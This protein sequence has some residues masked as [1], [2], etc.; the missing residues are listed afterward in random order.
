VRHCFN[1]DKNMIWDLLELESNKSSPERIY[2][3]IKGRHSAKEEGVANWLEAQVWGIPQNASDIANMHGVLTWA[4]R[5]M[6]SSGTYVAQPTVQ[7]NGTYQTWG[8]GT[9]TATLAGV[10]ASSALY[11][12]FRNAVATYSGSVDDTLLELIMDMMDALM[13]SPLAD[14]EGRFEVSDQIQ[15]WPNRLA[16]AYKKLVNKGNDD[17]GSGGKGDFFPIRQTTANGGRMVAVPYLD[18]YSYNPIIFCNLGGQQGLKLRKCAGRWDNENSPEKWDGSHTSY[19]QPCDYNGQIWTEIP[20]NHVGIL[21][22][23]F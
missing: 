5:S 10:D 4:K 20:R 17:R 19:C 23:S 2:Q 12:R 18:N 6:N 21:H 3:L 7:F 11:E 22:S 8:D 9:T 15:F 13:W 14:L 16:L 1:V